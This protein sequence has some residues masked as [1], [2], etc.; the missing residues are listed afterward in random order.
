MEKLK[1][2]GMSELRNRWNYTRQGVNLRIHEDKDFP[3]PYAIINCGKTKIW[4][5]S[6]IQKFMKI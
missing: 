3:V 6:D 2:L 1:L 5:L 4:L